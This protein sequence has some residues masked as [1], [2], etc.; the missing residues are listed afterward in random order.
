MFEGAVSQVLAGYLGR[1]VKGIQKDQLKIGLWNEEILLEN[2]ELMLEAFDYLQ[3]PFALK[4]GQIGK[5]S[6]RIPWKRF[7]REPIVVVIEDVFICACDR[8]DDEWRSDLVKGR[9]LAGKMAKLNA[10]E[11]AKFSRRVSDNQGGQSLM[12]YIT[13]KIIDS[14]QI[15]MR[16]V[17]IVFIDTHN[18]QVFLYLSVKEVMILRSG[19]NSWMNEENY[20][21][22]IEGEIL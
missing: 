18:E 4:N 15:S 6:I 14:I 10:I 3:L 8:R 5:L 2:V 7:G 9:E 21:I 17:H 12:S 20:W 16:N 11:L 1:Y 13:T 19:S 22:P